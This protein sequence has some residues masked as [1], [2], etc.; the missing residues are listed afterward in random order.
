MFIKSIHVYWNTFN[1]LIVLLIVVN[2]LYDFFVIK[3]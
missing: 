1:S 3:M 2:V